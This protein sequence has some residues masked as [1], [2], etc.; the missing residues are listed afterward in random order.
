MIGREAITSRPMLLTGVAR[1]TK[2]AGGTTLFLNS[3]HAQTQKIK[4]K[5]AGLI[6]FL[7]ELQFAPRLTSIERWCRILGRVLVKFLLI[8]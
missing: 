5:L 8:F 6:Q 1:A 2:H 4:E 3:S 7:R